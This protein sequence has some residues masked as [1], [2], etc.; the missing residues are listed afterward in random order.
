MQEI[1]L[2]LFWTLYLYLIHRWIHVYALKYFPLAFDAHMDHHRYVDVHRDKIKFHWKN[3][4]LCMDTWKSSLDVWITE[5]IPTILFCM[6]THQWWIFVFY[7]LWAVLLQEN[8]EHN[9]QINCYPILS[10]GLWHLAHHKNPDYNYGLFLPLWDELF[11]TNQ[12]LT[13]TLDN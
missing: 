6:L 1:I 10:T 12:G 3:I 2:F 7:Y 11:H 13:K 9:E 4:F 5:V 8:L